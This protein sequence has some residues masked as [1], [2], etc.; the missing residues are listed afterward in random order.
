M[1]RLNRLS[2]LEKLVGRGSGFGRRILRAYYDDN[3]LPMPEHL[4][5]PA[6]YT[7]KHNSF[8]LGDV[9]RVINGRI[10]RKYDHPEFK[11]H[12]RSESRARRA[13]SV[14]IEAKLLEEQQLLLSD[15]LAVLGR[16][17]N[18]TEE[19]KGTAAPTR[20]YGHGPRSGEISFEKIPPF[21]KYWTP[22]SFEHYIKLL[23]QRKN[24]RPGIG[25]R[26]ELLTP[27]LREL[28]RI[29]N[30]ATAGIKT[31][32]AYC[33]ALQ[34]FVRSYDLALVR[35]LF[36]QMRD[37]NVPYNVFAFN[38]VLSACAHRAGK[39]TDSSRLRVVHRLLTQMSNLGIRANHV[40]WGIILHIAQGRAAKMAVLHHMAQHEIDITPVFSNTVVKELSLSYSGDELMRVV[41]EELSAASIDVVTMTTLVNALLRENKFSKAWSCLDRLCTHYGVVPNKVTLNSFLRHSARVGRL[42]WAI[43]VWSGLTRRFGAAVVPDVFSYHY[44]VRAAVALGPRPNF[45]TVIRMVYS[46]VRQFAP[47]APLFRPTAALLTRPKLWARARGFNLDFRSAP[48]DPVAEKLWKTSCRLLRWS[49]HKA[50]LSHRLGSPSWNLAHRTFWVRPFFSSDHTI[51]AE[52]Q[53][54]YADSPAGSRIAL[55][56]RLQLEKRRLKLYKKQ[57]IRSRHYRHE[58]ILG[59]RE[60]MFNRG[61]Q[62]VLYEELYNKQIWE[63]HEEPKQ[64]SHSALY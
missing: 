52:L 22:E 58:R 19:R 48:A 37:E 15:C 64:H 11:E 62:M 39:F 45:A 21:P 61:L 34:Y 32:K 24:L 27:L 53:Q 10:V 47:N 17:M 26:H 30:S 7:V 28:F 29:N 25:S 51:V 18:N 16:N 38:I 56:G 43:G 8:G 40:T 2:Q 14:A 3:H 50:K 44:L 20:G 59:R 46:R 55:D 41:F 5:P 31:T 49:H 35:E 33:M 12:V 13:G 57:C 9:V 1:P 63:L 4:V 42:D 54:E 60:N 6:D 23:T 36:R